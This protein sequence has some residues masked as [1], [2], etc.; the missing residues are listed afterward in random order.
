MKNEYS[1]PYSGI[2]FHIEKVHSNSFSTA[3]YLHAQH[4]F[5]AKTF[6]TL[7]ACMSEA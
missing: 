4:L 6:E 7:Y 3:E 1:V 5:Q 2:I